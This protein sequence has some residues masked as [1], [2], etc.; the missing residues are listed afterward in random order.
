MS[1]QSCSAQPA[2]QVGGGEEHGGRGRGFFKTGAGEE[3]GSSALL[4]LLVYSFALLF[5][6]LL[7][8]FGLKQAL[9][10]S[11]WEPP[12]STL[13]PAIA[14]IATVNIVLVSYVIKAFRE[15]DKSKAD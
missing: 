12:V 14:A 4:G 15:E 3:T 2:E 6:P 7:V 11:D 10:D 13:A 9:E 5:L 1:R 8:Y